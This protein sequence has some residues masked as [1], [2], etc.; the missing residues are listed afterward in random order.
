MNVPDSNLCCFIPP[1]ME[2]LSDSFASRDIVTICTGCYRNL[3]RTMKDKEEYRI[4]MLPEIL[5]Q[6]LPG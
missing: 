6:A 3:R 2:K 1:H 4:W 5:L